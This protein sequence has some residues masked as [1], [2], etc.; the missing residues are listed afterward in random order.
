MKDW[1]IKLIEDEVSLNNFIEEHK[2]ETM[3]NIDEN[4]ICDCLKNSL[5]EFHTNFNISPTYQDNNTQLQFILIDDIIVF[6]NKFEDDWYLFEIIFYSQIDT[7]NSDYYNEELMWICDGRDGIK[8]I[9]QKLRRLLIDNGHDLKNINENVSGEWEYKLISFINKEEFKNEH[10]KILLNKKDIDGL[11]R[12]GQKLIMKNYRNITFKNKIDNQIKWSIITKFD[13][14]WYILSLQQKNWYLC[15]G[16]DGL[17]KC[18]NDNMSM[19]ESVSKKQYLHQED[20]DLISDIMLEYGDEFNMKEVLNGEDRINTYK[21]NYYYT[22][23]LSSNTTPASL[24][25]DISICCKDNR[26]FLMFEKNIEKIQNRII[27]FGYNC[28]I[29]Q[30]RGEYIYHGRI[31]K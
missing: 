30:N 22:I 19:N 18:M 1:I 10:K 26:Y 27:K 9:C 23:H 15:D 28:D 24:S 14:D 21:Y 25:I 16:L 13:D 11:K 6:F 20:A 3:L 12:T 17:I 2:E 31:T 29:Q 4:F 7:Q 5:K 8:E